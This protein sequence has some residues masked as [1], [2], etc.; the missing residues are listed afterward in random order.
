MFSKEKRKRRKRK[1]KNASSRENLISPSTHKECFSF[2]TIKCWRVWMML[3][4]TH[5]I[6]IKHIHEHTFLSNQSHILRYACVC[7]CACVSFCL[8]FFFSFLVV[9]NFQIYNSFNSSNAIQNNAPFWSCC[10]AHTKSPCYLV[11]VK[12]DLIWNKNRSRIWQ[13][14]F[15]YV[16]KQH[17]P[18]YGMTV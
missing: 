1:D 5:V 6:D 14:L 13:S 11:T 3:K 10:S 18:A 9:L 4:W 12:H 15:G 8:F 17:Y 16:F 7:L 2:W